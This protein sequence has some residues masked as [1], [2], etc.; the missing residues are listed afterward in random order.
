MAFDPPKKLRPGVL[1]TATDFN[2]IR[3]QLYA[4]GRPSANGNIGIEQSGYGQQITDLS[5]R[6]YLA[7]LT[8]QGDGVTAPKFAYGW[9]Q[10]TDNGDG[11]YT[12]SPTDTSNAPFGT[13]TAAPAYELNNRTN[14]PFG[15]STATP[16]G[17]IVELIPGQQDQAAFYF[18]WSAATATPVIVRLTAVGTGTDGGTAWAATTRHEVGGVEVDDGPLGGVEGAFVLYADKA[19]DGTD[20]VP[21]VGDYAIAIP[22]PDKSGIWGFQ[23]KLQT[24][25]TLCNGCGWL[26]SVQTKACLRI[27]VMGGVG[28]CSC[29]PADFPGTCADPGGTLAIY[30][31]T[32]FGGTGPLNGW[33]A[34]AL[35]RTCC[36]CGG[37]VL[38]IDPTKSLLERAT[39]SIL[40]VCNSCQPLGSGAVRKFT[41][42]LIVECCGVD[43]CGRNYVQFVGYSRDA[44]ADLDPT[45]CGPVY[46]ILVTCVDCPAAVC[47]CPGCF[48]EQTPEAFYFVDEDG[49]EHV[50]TR[51]D[52]PPLDTWD[53]VGGACV[54]RT[55]G[56]G[57]Y[58]S[59]ADCLTAC[60]V[61]PTWA[62]VDAACVEKGDGT[63][64]Y[65]SL[66]ACQAAC[67]P[68]KCCTAYLSTSPTGTLVIP[69]GP[70]SAGSPYSALGGV[71]SDGSES[72]IESNVNDLFFAVK[73]DI[74]TGTWTGSVNGT[75]VDISVSC[76]PPLTA[77]MPGTAFGA[78]GTVSITL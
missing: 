75:P 24:K 45:L 23:P 36:G 26:L 13:S 72:A 30:D 42:I 49:C 56:S 78:T 70:N 58:S 6:R 28:T 76:G 62:C 66:A 11:T 67:G 17:P 48:G 14:V 40:N 20:G 63:G 46:R 18:R 12:D 61:T 31:G 41:D 59:I 7:R 51:Q 29:I 33:V 25:T 35:K 19:W 71:S 38:R 68:D 64:A 2:A 44:C 55:D 52:N 73:C 27:R 43:A 69:D 65:T 53:C 57:A 9:N 74:A 47:D 4:L 16:P 39:L 1:P 54:Q 77:T 22:D 3:K 37:A 8:S 21:E 10:V 15:L 34:T 32:N 5:P 60:G 50:M